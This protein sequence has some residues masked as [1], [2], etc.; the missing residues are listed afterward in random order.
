MMLRSKSHL[1]IQTIRGI[2]AVFND[3]VSASVNERDHIPLQVDSF[4]P[5]YSLLDCIRNT[6]LLIC[7]LPGNILQTIVA[8]KQGIFSI[9]GLEIYMLQLISLPSEM[10]AAAR[11]REKM[12]SFRR[13][14]TYTMEDSV[15]VKG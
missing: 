14:I 4:F 13:L 7:F 11:L 10:A 3:S 5:P 6:G 12:C 15:Q 9:L 1:V 8:R 2:V